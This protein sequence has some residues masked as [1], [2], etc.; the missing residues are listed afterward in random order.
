MYV[1]TESLRVAEPNCG[2]YLHIAI[3]VFMISA[4]YIPYLLLLMSQNKYHYS[5]LTFPL[6]RDLYVVVLFS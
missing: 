1:F 4:N 3:S 6:D 2:L 5:S